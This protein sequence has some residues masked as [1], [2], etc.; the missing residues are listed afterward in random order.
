MKTSI[1]KDPAGFSLAQGVPISQ[2]V[3]LSLVFMA[4]AAVGQVVLTSRGFSLTAELVGPMANGFMFSVLWVVRGLTPSN[5][6]RTLI[7][8]TVWIT[9]SNVIEFQIT[10]LMT[11][12]VPEQQEFSEP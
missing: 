2:R 6:L 8:G 7:L 9:L 5:I 10:S 12:P 4:A 3:E 11:S 1:V